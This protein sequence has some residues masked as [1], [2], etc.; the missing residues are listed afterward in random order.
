M[1]EVLGLR[2]ADGRE[3]AVKSR[4]DQNGREATCVEVQRILADQGFP[5]AAPLTGVTVGEGTA[6][7]AEQWR[8]GG[9]ML[10]GDDPATAALFGTLLA[11]LVS[12]AADI[13]VGG[14]APGAVAPPLPNPDGPVGA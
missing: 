9:E 11:S 8:P 10:R 14:S 3:V 2:L 6:I 5:C 13:E 12:L 4:P 1:S 7:H